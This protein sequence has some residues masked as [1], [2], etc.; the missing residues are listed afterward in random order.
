MLRSAHSAKLALVMIWLGAAPALAQSSDNSLNLDYLHLP[1]DD[2]GFYTVEGARTLNAGEIYGAIDFNHAHN[3]LELGFPGDSRARSVVRQLSTVN[4]ALGIGIFDGFSLGLT[5]PVVVDN[6]GRELLAPDFGTND[7]RSGGVAALRLEAKWVALDTRDADDSRGLL[8]TE[9]DLEFAVSVSP[10]VTLPTGRARDYLTDQNNPTGGGHVHV[11]VELFRRLRLGGSLG[12]EFLSSSVDIGD[13]EIEDRLRFGA[14]VEV[15]IVRARAARSAPVQRVPANEDPVEQRRALRALGVLASL[16]G[17]VSPEEAR[18]LRGFAEALGIPESSREALLAPGTLDTLR[19]LDRLRVPLE[20]ARLEEAALELLSLNPDRNPQ[21]VEGYRVLS[22]KQE[23][24]ALEAEG[25]L[26]TEGRPG[27][28]ERAAAR[29][30]AEDIRGEELEEDQFPHSLSIGAEVFGWTD[31]GQPFHNERERP[32]EVGGYLRYS[33]T[34]GL[35]L[36][37]GASFGLTNGVSAP[38]A[39][40]VLGIGW[41][42]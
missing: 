36:R 14:A 42:F 1:T 26:R 34:V 18:L 31:A 27:W 25:A 7:T 2:S 17:S 15:L 39:R 8:E 5:L 41:R 9:E 32:I 16:D 3:P 20:R 38:D 33:H 19:I 28:F 6:D 23:F 22:R 4:V 35:S 37:V 24:A 11:E 21:T 40:Y 10:F 29:V 13:I 12:V 30:P